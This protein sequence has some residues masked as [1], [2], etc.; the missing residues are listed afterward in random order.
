MVPEISVV[1]PCYNEE[2]NIRLGVLDKVLLYLEKQTYPWEVLII[3]DG[4]TDASRHLIK[5]F[6][7]K[8]DH[9]FRLIENPHQGKAGTVVTGMLS[10]RGAYILFTDLD[11]ATPIDQIEKLRPWFVK[12]FDIVIGSRKGRRARAPFLRKL[13]GPGFTFVRNLILGLGGLNDT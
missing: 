13:M 2:Q 6:I 7:K 4:S 3:D 1:I 9:G 5:E 10:A 8:N 11:Q 12:G